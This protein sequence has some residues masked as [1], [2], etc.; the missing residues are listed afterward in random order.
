MFQIETIIYRKITNMQPYYESRKARGKKRKEDFLESF[1]Y[2]A[3]FYFFFNT[4]NQR[5]ILSCHII[6]T[7]IFLYYIVSYVGVDWYLCC[8]LFASCLLLGW[9]GWMLASQNHQNKQHHFSLFFLC[10]KKC[11]VDRNTPQPQ[12]LTLFFL[13]HLSY[14]LIFLW[15]S[16]FGD[17]NKNC[18]VRKN[19]C[20]IYGISRV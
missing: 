18:R 6:I 14:I 2:T 20:G 8:Q 5:C 10:C 12:K 1:P 16:L 11:S 9:A 7:Y 13:H 19:N 17:A 3:R 4:H 15:F